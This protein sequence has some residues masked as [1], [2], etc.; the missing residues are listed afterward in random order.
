MISPAALNKAI[1]RLDDSGKLDFIF[2]K[3]GAN[4]LR[5]LNEV[6]KTIFTVP[7]SAAINHSN[8]AA[9]LSAAMD[10]VLSGMSGFPAPVA[11]ALRLSTKHIKDR[12]IRKRVEDALNPRS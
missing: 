11:S 2:G 1:K 4:K 8:T 7:A 5:A 3:Q 10:L 12:K 6:S 9:T